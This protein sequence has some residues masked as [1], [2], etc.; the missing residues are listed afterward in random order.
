M[1]IVCVCEIIIKKTKKIGRV[2]TKFASIKIVIESKTSGLNLK[3]KKRLADLKVQ[4]F[5][6]SQIRKAHART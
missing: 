1:V 3:K 2:V 4:S 5:A 6:L